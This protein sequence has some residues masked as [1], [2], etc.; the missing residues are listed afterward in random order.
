MLGAYSGDIGF[1]NLIDDVG[2]DAE[3]GVSHVQQ[4]TTTRNRIRGGN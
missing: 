2:N 3:V 4:L 1:K